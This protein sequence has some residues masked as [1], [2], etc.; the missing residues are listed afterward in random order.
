MIEIIAAQLGIASGGQD[1]ENAL[2]QSE[3]GNIEGSSTQIIGG[4]NTFGSVV[5]PISDCGGSRF[6]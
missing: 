5:Q 4:K 1:F 2:V 3:N 6:A